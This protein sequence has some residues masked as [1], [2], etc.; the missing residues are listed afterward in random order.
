[1]FSV[2]ILFFLDSALSNE[3]ICPGAPM[4]AGVFD[5]PNGCDLTCTG[6]ATCMDA[7]YN[8]TDV[9]NGCNF[10]CFGGQAGIPPCSN[11]EIYAYGPINLYCGE[12]GCKLFL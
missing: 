10:T 9:V 4:C 8:C 11:F 6:V 1:M 7:L 12:M 5:C 3:I 2:V